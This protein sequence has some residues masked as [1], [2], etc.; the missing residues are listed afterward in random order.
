M[1]ALVCA[2][3]HLLRVCAHL[4]VCQCLRPV[5]TRV[6]MRVLLRVPACMARRRCQRRRPFFLSL[7]WGVAEFW[8]PRQ[9]GPRWVQRRVSRRDRSTFCGPKMASERLDVQAALEPA[10]L[11]YHL[12]AEQDNSYVEWRQ[13]C[14]YVFEEQPEFN[15]NKHPYDLLAFKV[16]LLVNSGNQQGPLREFDST[17]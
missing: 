5:C 16:E 7:M 10:A 6:P 4:H 14:T 9:S 8:S 15:E 11:E 13:P 3:V 12:L 17:G 2:C 1:R